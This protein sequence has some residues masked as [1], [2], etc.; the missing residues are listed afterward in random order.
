MRVILSGTAKLLE[1]GMAPDELI[2][3]VKSP[4]GTTEAGL[5][6]FDELGLKDIVSASVEAAF[7]RAGELAK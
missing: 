7:K 6:K 2:R 3:M 1:D 5:D 4:G